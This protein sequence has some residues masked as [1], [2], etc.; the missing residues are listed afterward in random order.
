[1]NTIRCDRCS[2]HIEETKED[3]VRRTLLTPTGFSAHWDYCHPAIE[4]CEKCF[5]HLC[6]AWTPG[7]PEPRNEQYIDAARELL[8]LAQESGGISADKELARLSQ[9]LK[10]LPR[11]S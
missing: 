10:H 2:R 9:I 3:E 7:T 11:E 5:D 4:L 8:V 1:M 6:D